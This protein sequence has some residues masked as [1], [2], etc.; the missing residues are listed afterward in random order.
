MYHVEKK[1]EEKPLVDGF[2]T[3]IH[4]DER[5]QDLLHIFLELNLFQRRKKC[6]MR[7]QE[8]FAQ[9]KSL[10]LNKASMQCSEMQLSV[11]HVRQLLTD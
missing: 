9:N 6:F 5:I 4:V 10:T 8:A 11:Y 3:F 2:V 1:G 7:P